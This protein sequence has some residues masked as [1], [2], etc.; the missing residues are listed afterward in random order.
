MKIG[1]KYCGGCNPRFNRKE[2][3]NKLDAYFEDIIFKPINESSWYDIVIVVCGCL[4]A[5]VN[6]ESINSN[7][8]FEITPATSLIDIKK[9][10]SSSM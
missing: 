6:K 9:F 2:T 10:I 1:I 8:I 3:I 5:C 4:T 7:K